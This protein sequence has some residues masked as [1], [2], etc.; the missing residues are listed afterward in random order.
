MGFQL[1][2]YFFEGYKTLLAENRRLLV[3]LCAQIYLYTEEK[4]KKWTNHLTIVQT[5]HTQH[6]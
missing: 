3:F 2:E 6:T 1:K 5:A 4:R